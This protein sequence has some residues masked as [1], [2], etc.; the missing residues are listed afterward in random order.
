MSRASCS[1]RPF[2]RA[3][4]RRTFVGD[5]RTYRATARARTGAAAELSAVVAATFSPL[6]FRPDLAPA[7]LAVVLDVAPEGPRGR[8]LAQ[9]V[10]DHRVRDEDRHVLAAV[11]HR[12]RVADHVGDDGRPTGPGPDDGLLARLVE[13]VH[14]LEQVVVHERALLQ[15]A[16]HWLP[17]CSALLAGT[18]PA[19]DQLV[20]RLGAA[21]AALWLA[22]GVDRVA[23]TG[24][25]ALTTTVR[26][27]D[28]VHGHTADGRALALPPHPAGLAPVDVGMV[29]VADLA[30]GGAAA[31]VDVADLAGRHA[32]LRVGTV[33]GDQ[34]HAGPGGP[35]DLGAATGPELD[36]VHHGAGRDVAQRQVVAHLD[37]RA[38]P[39]LDHVALLELRRRDDVALLTVGV[40]Q[41][42]D[43]RGAVRVVLDVRD[44]GRHT[45]LVVAPEVDQPVGTLVP[46]ALVPGGDPPVHVATALGVQRTDQ[47]LLRRRPGDLGEVRDA[48]AAA[49]R[50]RRLVLADAHYSAPQLARP[51]KTSIVR[52]SAESVTIA[53]LTSLRLP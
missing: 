26:V 49:A 43:P 14:L 50:R 34:L 42:C 52:L 36:R 37:V 4:T 12:D 32:Q 11:V 25:L 24:G 48:G 19:D 46:T 7:R 3:M 38:R 13:D 45:V 53:R 18:T 9:L 22:R 2:T 29:G 33:L 15:A 40:V 10:T 21:G 6:L 41:Q 1:G 35:G 20:G 27:V 47:R 5:M 39:G 8:E 23:T 16:R 51:P 28:R 17:P 30:D 31:H 44:L